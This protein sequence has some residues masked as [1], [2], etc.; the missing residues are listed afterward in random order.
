MRIRCLEEADAQ[1]AMRLE[2]LGA[3]DPTTRACSTQYNLLQLARDGH[4]DMAGTIQTKLDEP[5]IMAWRWLNAAA[6]QVWR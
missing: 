6:M 2:N 5:P 4:R 1:M 3:D